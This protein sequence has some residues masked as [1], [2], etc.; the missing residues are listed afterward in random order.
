M[1]VKL[2]AMPYHRATSISTELHKQKVSSGRPHRAGPYVHFACKRRFSK[3]T[4]PLI[5]RAIKGLGGLARDYPYP[6]FNMCRVGSTWPKALRGLNDLRQD[7]GQ[8]K[9][10]KKNKKLIFLSTL[11]PNVNE[12]LSHRVKH[13]NTWKVIQFQ[14]LDAKTE[15][16]KSPRSV[17]PR[18]I[19]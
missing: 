15:P 14:Q 11:P 19:G 1:S 16:R 18:G 5:A 2:I 6:T 4:L 12:T 13:I 17:Q 8:V 9:G 3:L 10:L 7:Q